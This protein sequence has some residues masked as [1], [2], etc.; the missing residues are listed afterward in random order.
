[1][2]GGRFGG[3]GKTARVARTMVAAGVLAVAVVGCTSGGTTPDSG[4]DAPTV[5]LPPV[6]MPGATGGAAGSS[7]VATPASLTVVEGDQ[8]TFMVSL[9][10]AFPTPVTISLTT[11]DP[12]VATVAQ[13][14]LVFPAN[15]TGPQLVTVLGTRDDDTV[16]NS[17]QVTLSGPEVGTAMV[18]VTVSDVNKQAVVAAP[19]QVFM[20]QGATTQVGIRLA[21]RPSD[22]VTVTVTSP[23]PTALAV[24]PATLTFA[25]DSTYSIAQQITLTAAT[26]AVGDQTVI[27]SVSATGVDTILPIPVVI[28]DPNM[29]NLVVTPGMLSLTQG[30][31]PGTFTVNLTKAPPTP[32]SV[33]I[34]SSSNVQ[35]LPSPVGLTFDATNYNVPQTV[36]V[37]PQATNDTKDQTATITVAVTTAVTPAVT[38]RSVS[39]AIKSTQAQ[40]IQVLPTEVTVSQGGSTTFDVWMAFNPGAAISVNA[41]SSNPSRV[42]ITPT[43]LIFNATNFGTHQKITVQGL[44]GEDLSDVMASITLTSVAANSVTVPVTV[45]NTNAQAIQVVYGTSPGAIVM[46]ETQASGPASTTTFGVSLAFNPTSDVA[47]TLTA[48][49]PTRLSISKSILTFNPAG[50]AAPGKTTQ[51][52]TL[53]SVHDSDLLDNTVKLTVSAPGLTPVTVTIQ[54]LD[55]DVERLTVTQSGMAVASIDTMEASTNTSFDVGLTQLPPVPLTV[56]LV[57]SD[58]TRVAVPASITLSNTTPLTVPVTVPKDPDARPNSATIT[59]HVTTATSLSIPDRTVTVNIADVD[60]QA[61]VVGQMA[62]LAYPSPNFGLTVHEVSPNAAMGPT[63]ATFLVALNAQPD[64]DTTVGLSFTPSVAPGLGLTAAVG[65]ASSLTFTRDNWM[66]P[67]AVVV[68][69]MH[70]ANLSTD[71]FNVRV[72]APTLGVAD[73]F[74]GVTEIDDDKQAISVSKSSLAPVEH[75]DN[76]QFAVKLQF[77]PLT[78][79]AVTA[80]I[81]SDLV[82][83]VDFQSPTPTRNPDGSESVT[84]TFSADN[85]ATEQT[86]TVV[87]TSDLNTN[88]EKGMINVSLPAFADSVNL[89][90]TGVDGDQQEILVVASACDTM[91]PLPP[92]ITLNE[93][94][95]GAPRT[96]SR[97][98]LVTLKYPPNNNNTMSSPE[99]ISIPSNMSTKLEVRDGS[100]VANDPT[101]LIFTRDNYNVA[102][103]F[104]LS[105]RADSDATDEALAISVSSNLS[106]MAQ[107]GRAWT[108]TPKTIN[109]QIQDLDADFTVTRTMGTGSVDQAGTAS[110]VFTVTLTKNPTGNLT[111]T[112]NVSVADGNRVTIAPASLTFMHASGTNPPPAQTFTVTGKMS[113]DTAPQTVNITVSATGVPD[114]TV[115]VMLTP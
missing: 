41:F 52:V 91:C 21:F 48:D 15:D 5:D 89:P 28:S 4:T 99:T 79:T 85:Y 20:Q 62:P 23:N 109:V 37:T 63:T 67:Q 100:G 106:G 7:L 3:L 40:A 38:P 14:T 12:T 29:L 97:T 22:P 35:A 103:S 17:T 83:H 33:S 57:S 55:M 93:N 81:P 61:I 78:M 46:Q 58:P 66:T 94:A 13:N 115:S 65:G 43:T 73:Q 2:T 42:A 105:S 32:L 25:N 80:T 84:L 86:V 9:S 101:Q 108:A 64:G 87:A 6:D 10:K 8:A 51:F 69:G 71:L 114:K 92:L 77:Q 1:M 27:L 102:Q 104:V 31:T 24:T 49:D 34:T 68:T 96:T 53:A 74:V 72:S 110:S 98:F 95:Q 36:T 75:G 60:T 39:V 90:V 113:G 82:G 19:T 88:D 76:D 44:P 107:N 30:G 70:D 18:H 111:V 50:G 56:T 16:A 26:G 59:L 45:K 54:I 11:G 112:A 47:V